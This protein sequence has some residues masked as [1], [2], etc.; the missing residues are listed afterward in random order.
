MEEG[1]GQDRPSLAPP[2]S[3]GVVTWVVSSL[4]GDTS[5]AIIRA[6]KV[7]SRCS[8]A[9]FQP[10]RFPHMASYSAWQKSRSGTN[11][12]SM[13]HITLSSHERFPFLS[14]CQFS[15]S[16]FSLFSLSVPF[17]L[18]LCVSVFFC[19]SLCSV[20]LSSFYFCVPLTPLCS[21]S[22]PF[23]PFSSFTGLFIYHNPVWTYWGMK[24]ASPF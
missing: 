2:L 18:C 12:F 10:V 13:K 3:G 8:E 19:L 22:L 21:P 1:R 11:S 6:V 4:T 16:L 20:S 15:L 7:L 24:K 23:F 14:L 5:C 17:P 9:G